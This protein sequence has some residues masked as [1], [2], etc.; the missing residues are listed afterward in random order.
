MNSETCERWAFSIRTVSSVRTANGRNRVNVC[1]VRHLLRRRS[2]SEKYGKSRT[3]SLA[4][5]RASARTGN[6][7]SACRLSIPSALCGVRHYQTR[8]R[9]VEPFKN[10]KFIPAKST[11]VQLC[12]RVPKNLILQGS[13]QPEWCPSQFQRDK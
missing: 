6:P 8:V 10:S 2:R 7:G 12:I 4:W 5:L 11:S 3:I 1:A 9:S 13:D